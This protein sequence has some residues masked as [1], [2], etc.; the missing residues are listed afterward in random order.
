MCLDSNELKHIH[1]L[2]KKNKKV[3]FSSN[4]V[5]R[6]NDLFNKIKKKTN[7]NDLF[8]SLEANKEFDTLIY[9]HCGG[10]Y[11]DIKYAHDG[12]FE[13]SV[14][15]HSSWGS[16][17]WILNDALEE[18]YRVGIVGNSDGHKGRPGASCVYFHYENGPQTKTGWTVQEGSKE[19]G[20]R[21]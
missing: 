5:L 18:G 17:E 1:N 15:V 2:I 11:A 12:R 7:L 16:F 6:T 8:L 21:T 19:A 4:L 13:K 20:S 10:R 14:E 3:F 9:A